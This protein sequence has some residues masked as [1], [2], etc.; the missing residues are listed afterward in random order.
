MLYEFKESI[1]GKQRSAEK[2]HGNAAVA[3]A[4]NWLRQT[5][6]SDVIGDAQKEKENAQANLNEMNR[7]IQ[8][9]QAAQNS[10]QAEMAGYDE[11]LMAV[12]TDMKA[13]AK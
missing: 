3:C 1:K 2:T 9:I 11:Q 7:Q 8:G 10:L 6:C 13:A 4:W 12:L 5:D